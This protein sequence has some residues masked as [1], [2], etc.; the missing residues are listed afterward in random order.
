MLAVFQLGAMWVGMG[1]WNSRFRGAGGP[2]FDE[3]VVAP[4]AGFICA[5]T[6]T[7]RQ[8]LRLFLG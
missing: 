4:G 8:L 1:M 7:L 6:N 3:L 2:G 5:L